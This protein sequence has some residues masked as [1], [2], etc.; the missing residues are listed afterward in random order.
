M[1]NDVDE[2]VEEGNVPCVKYVGELHVN[3]KSSV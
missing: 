1:S 2:G 3:G